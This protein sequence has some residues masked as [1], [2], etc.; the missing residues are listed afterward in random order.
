M[1]AGEKVAPVIG[2]GCQVNKRWITFSHR[3]AD[4]SGLQ[5]VGLTVQPLPGDLILD[6][7][8]LG[9]FLLLLGL[10]LVLGVDNVLVIAIMVS[11]LPE[12]MRAKARFI[13]LALAMV[14]RLLLLVMVLFLARLEKPVFLDFSVRDLLLILGGMFLLWK[15]VKEI[16]HVVELKGPPDA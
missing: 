11:R 9:V 2:R 10:E 15:A 13:G 14:A 7:H 6:I 12:S 3:F 1:I 8:L 16:H 5:E 4:G